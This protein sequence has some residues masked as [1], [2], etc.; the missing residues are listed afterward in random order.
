M[1]MNHDARARRIE[2]LKDTIRELL[3]V[4]DEAQHDPTA[5][6]DIDEPSLER[7]FERAVARARMVSGSPLSSS[8][9]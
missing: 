6:I 2:Q 7:R 9:N 4:L 3:D 1:S 5:V 8:R